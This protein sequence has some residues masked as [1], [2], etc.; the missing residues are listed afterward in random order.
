MTT[1]SHTGHSKL[2]DADA[3]ALETIERRNRIERE[4]RAF[5]AQ[6][7]AAILCGLETPAG[8]LGRQHGPRRRQDE[9]VSKHAD[10]ALHPRNP[11]ARR[12]G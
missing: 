5:V 7:R 12:V 3:I 9:R 2:I 4:D 8:V 1:A 11:T 10:G 6:L